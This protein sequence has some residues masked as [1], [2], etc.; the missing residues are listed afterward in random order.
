MAPYFVILFLLL[1]CWIWL[2]KRLFLELAALVLLLLP[3]IFFFGQAL[4]PLQGVVIAPS[5]LRTDGN[6][7]ASLV[8]EIPLQKGEAVR[9][10]GVTSDG[11]WLRVY[12]ED[13]RYGFLEAK[14]VK[15]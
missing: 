15:V 9:V 12:A 11:T 7:S 1:S 13:G 6:K 10:V 5:L 8:D 2:R 3:L 4:S 14:L